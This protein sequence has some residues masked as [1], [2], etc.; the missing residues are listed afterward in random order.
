MKGDEEKCLQAGCDGYLSKPVDRKK[1]YK[2]LRRYL[3]VV[4]KAKT[5]PLAKAAA[6]Q[7]TADSIQTQE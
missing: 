4:E 3:S 6:A 1:L 2:I 5:L 7:P